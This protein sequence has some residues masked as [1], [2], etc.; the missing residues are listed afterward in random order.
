M[1]Q[2]AS[3]GRPPTCPQK[4]IPRS[5]QPKLPAG[6][7]VP[8]VGVSCQ[9]FVLLGEGARQGAAGTL[10]MWNSVV[11]AVTRPHIADGEG[12]TS[13][14]RCPE[15]GPWQRGTP[16]APISSPTAGKGC[17]SVAA[18][19]SWEYG[20]PLSADFGWANAVASF[21]P[22]RR[23]KKPSWFQPR[24]RAARLTSRR[25]PLPLTRTPLHVW[26]QRMTLGGKLS[27][28]L[29]VRLPNCGGSLVSGHAPPCRCTQGKA[30]VCVYGP[31]AT[32]AV[33]ELGLPLFEVPLILCG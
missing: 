25:V 3:M 30:F 10:I 23:G 21:L 29:L 28:Y 1:F 8:V 17:S 5:W 26:H 22:L 19:S 14:Y 12:E 13:Q 11:S 15:L 27:T 4:A 9:T 33:V 16:T 2:S 18:T 20:V 31:V 24:A 32:K 6:L 7:A